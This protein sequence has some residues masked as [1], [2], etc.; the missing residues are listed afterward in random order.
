MAPE[1]EAENRANQ[2]PTLGGENPQALRGAQGQSVSQVMA[3]RN[4]IVRGWAAYFPLTEEKGVLAGT[5]WLNPAQGT[6]AIMAALEARLY[7]GAKSEARGA[8]S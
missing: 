3:E 5:R 4:L 6:S 7:A 2:P 1:T 8:R